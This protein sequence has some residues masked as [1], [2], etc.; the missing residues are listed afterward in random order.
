MLRLPIYFVKPSF[1]K[2]PKKLA[3]NFLHAI[4][5]TLAT[6]YERRKNAK[7]TW[8]KER[9]PEIDGGFPAK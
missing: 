9:S 5:I 6:T 7:K 1:R 4:I 2:N 3:Y 8:L